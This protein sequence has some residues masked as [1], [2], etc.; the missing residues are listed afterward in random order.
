MVDAFA[1]ALLVDGARLAFADGF[2]GD[3]FEWIEC[4]ARNDSVLAY[5]RKAKDP[6]DCL[7]VV[8]NFTPAYREAYPI[9][10][11]RGGWYQEVFNSDSQYY[12]GSNK[13]NYPGVMAQEPGWHFRSH[14]LLL[15]LP[16]LAT[17]VLKPE[18]LDKSKTV[19]AAKQKS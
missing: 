19:E 2:D 5:M 13:G 18:K 3:G 17:V 6:E 12:G 9:G 14:K 16:P 4:T 8:Q 1:G 11:P 10:A 15:N 7:I